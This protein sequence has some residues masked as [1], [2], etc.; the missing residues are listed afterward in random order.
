MPMRRRRLLLA[1]LG[2]R[3]IAKVEADRTCRQ[4]R[5]VLMA[6]APW[7]SLEG[8][9]GT[10]RAV[11]AGEGSALSLSG[12]EGEDVPL[13]VETGRRSCGVMVRRG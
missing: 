13:V 8:I 9:V 5:G 1:E 7:I 3:R 11:V 6:A 4:L 2:S 12:P 10:R